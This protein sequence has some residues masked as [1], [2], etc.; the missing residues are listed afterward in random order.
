M[1]HK[2]LTEQVQDVEISGEGYRKILKALDI[3]H[4]TVK[5]I[6]NKGRKY[7][8]TV[9]FLRTRRTPKI[10]GKTSRE[11]IREAARG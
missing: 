3:S 8:T 9:T 6:I 4:N 7:G 11:L 5:I 2:E 10:D 1:G